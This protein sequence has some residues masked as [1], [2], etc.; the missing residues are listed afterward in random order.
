MKFLGINLVGHDPGFSIV[1][2]GEIQ[3]VLELERVD[4]DRYADNWTFTRVKRVNKLNNKQ[5]MA[6]AREYVKKTSFF[7]DAHIQEI[8]DVTMSGPG[9][10]DVIELQ[11]KCSNAVVN[12]LKER[13]SVDSQRINYV[14]HHVCHAASA[15]FTSPFKESVIISFDGH[16]DDGTCRVFHGK[17]NT[18]TPIKDYELYFGWTYKFNVFIINDDFGSRT[19]SPG[20]IMGLSS[21]GEVNQEYYDQAVSFI[22]NFKP[23]KASSS[24]S[25]QYIKDC[26]L[27]KFRGVKDEEAQN[28]AASFQKAWSDT[29]IDKVVKPHV[30]KDQNLCLTGGCALNGL[31]NYKIFSDVTKNLYVPPNPSDS[32]LASGAALHRY[33]CNHEYHPKNFES[34][35]KGMKMIDAE[36]MPSYL[37]R[38]EYR[39]EVDLDQ[40]CEIIN[41]NKTV[42]V[43]SGKSEIGPRALGNRSII[44]DCSKG[45]M[46]DII[47]NKIKHR[48]WYRPFAPIIR[49]EDAQEYFD[50]DGDSYYMSY[51]VPCTTKCQTEFPAITHVDNTGR[52]QTVTKQSH[53]FLYDLLSNYK[54]L[55]D[56]PV[57]LN[58]SFNIQGNAIISSLKEA[59]RAF[60]ETD[61]DAL[62]IDKH[63]WTK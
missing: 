21:Y 7:W 59:F 4:G 14:S 57:L 8:N 16:G 52:L 60:D 39:G 18:I 61:L 23:H 30:Q 63:M 20:K 62:L 49:K 37:L 54:R 32:G 40:I 17:N 44:C 29:F 2:N 47:N 10:P 26:G 5:L 55:Y 31:T 34:A 19:S 36:E 35:L 46:K 45:E 9:S 3:D 50:F 25:D 42:A 33:Y 48:A 38:K 56:R 24:Q 51:V 13:Y 12:A 22:L 11:R 53:Q 41:A 28:W 6:H 27:T 43:M 1:E 58:T 15:F